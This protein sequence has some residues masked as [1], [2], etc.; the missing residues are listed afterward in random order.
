MQGDRDGALLAS[1]LT[2]RVIWIGLIAE[3]LGVAGF[4]LITLNSHTG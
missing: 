2:R 1:R 4:I 3:A